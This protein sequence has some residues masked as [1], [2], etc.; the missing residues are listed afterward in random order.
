MK[1]M[2]Q[3]FFQ[4]MSEFF[5]LRISHDENAVNEEKSDKVGLQHLVYDVNESGQCAQSSVEMCLTG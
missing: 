2:I 1:E 3:V 5:T 4:K